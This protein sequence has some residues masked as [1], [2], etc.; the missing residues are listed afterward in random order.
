VVDNYTGSRFIG[1]IAAVRILKLNALC[2]VKNQ[3]YSADQYV[4]A[5]N[6]I[7]HI[8]NGFFD[9][10]SLF[11]S[12]I[13]D[14]EQVKKLLSVS[15][16]RLKEDRS[17]KV[18]AALQKPELFLETYKEAIKALEVPVP[19]QILFQSLETLE[20]IC[21]LH[22]KVYSNPFV[23]SISQGY[24][25]S[26]FSAL[27]L[28]DVCLLPFCNP[29]LSFIESKIIPEITEY[30]P[31]ILLLMGKPNIASFAIGKIMRERNPKVFIVAA[32]YESDYYSLKKIKN[33]LAFNSAF[34]SVYHCVLINDT[35]NTV[36]AIKLILQE[37]NAANMSSI[38]GIIYSLDN[39]NTIFQTEECPEQPLPQAISYVRKG[40]VLNIKA[41]PQNHCY[42]NQCTFCG[43]NSKYGS[44]KTQ[45][46]DVGSF[47]ARLKTLYA[48]GIR[49]IWLLDEAIPVSALRNFA[50]QL[51][52]ADMQII[53]HTRTR[54]ETQFIEE[55]L[56]KLLKQSGLRHI[57]FGFESASERI[58]R[59]ANKTTPNFRYLETAEKIVRAFTVH[60]IAVHFSAILGFPSETSEERRETQSFLKYML[61]T[62]QG[63][64]YNVNAFYLDVGSEMYRRWESFDI[65]SLSF[66]CAPRYFLEN[67]LDWNSAVSPNKFTKIQKEQESLMAEQ[68]P[69][70]PK[71]ALLSPSAFFAFWEYS[72]YCLQTEYF[73]ANAFAAPPSMNRPIK[74]SPMV[75]FDQIDVN[76]WQLYHLQNHHYVVGGSILRD[77]V[78]A[79]NMGISFN[80]MISRYDSP[81][82]Q[83]A[84]SLI[85]ELSRMDFFT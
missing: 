77:L 53:W 29:Y 79:D 11:W 6:K 54:I 73:T 69:W 34:F 55:E 8:C 52:S 1:G 74:L 32:E 39:G 30:H 10:N 57:L 19:E 35:P 72:R 60:G 44:R 67:Y 84:E 78:N 37:K 17:P 63:F 50:E 22:S 33:L 2:G 40:A 68:Y 64:S 26:K 42:W 20:I 46:W 76:L 18:L 61:K 66:P 7:A 3:M 27:D 80:K 58:L 13:F 82:R 16:I 70:Y 12:C 85:Q 47:I 43:I 9:I 4:I 21:Y 38:P 65:S 59:L 24:I 81:Y 48:S 15:K 83:R 62:Y 56:V 5:N 51:L 71:G 25:H 75:C 36:E 23:L 41:F 31:D 14:A 49:K 28:L 45:K